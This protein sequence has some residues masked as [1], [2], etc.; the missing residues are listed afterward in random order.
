MKKILLATDFSERSD[1]ALR[2]ASLLARGFDAALSIVHVVDDDQPRRIVDSEH[3]AAS[4]LLR[5]LRNTVRDVD[6][7]ACDVRVIVADPF[8][9]IARATEE[10]TPD[11][12][13]IGPHRRQMLRDVFVGTT[14]ERTI[15]AV[16]CPVLMVNAPPV[17]AYRHVLL[18]TDLSEAAVRVA[19]TPAVRDIAARAT[20]T[21][22]HVFDAPALHMAMSHTIPAEDRDAYRDDQHRAASRALAEFVA[23]AEWRAIR[24]EVRQA[25]KAPAEEILSMARDLPADLLVVGTHGRGGLARLLLGSVAETVLR[26]AE[27][28]VLA[29][30][31][32]ATA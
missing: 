16:G 2:R 13:V 20:A 9:G 15:R 6:G 25:G 18:T 22:L 30:P 27:I 31:P 23:A 12:L 4:E 24:Q 11:L 17:A 28:D 3:A 29:V 32:A 1:R 7:I 5:E 21:I 10:D 14:A 8:A 19:T 26:E